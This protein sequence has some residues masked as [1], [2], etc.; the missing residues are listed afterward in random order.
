VFVCVAE[1][2]QAAGRER[3]RYAGAQDYFDRLDARTLPTHEGELNP[4]FT[5][6]YTSHILVK[7]RNRAAETALL[8][9]EK[10]CAAASALFAAAYPTCSLNSLWEC[11]SICQF[12]D[13]ICGCHVDEVTDDLNADYERIIRQS[14]RL[15][16]RALSVLAAEG[17][18]RA[19]AMLVFNPVAAP[20]RDM[21]RVAASPDW[22]PLDRD[23]QTLPAQRD[24]DATCVLV[25]SPGFGVSRL[26]G[27]AA[28]PPAAEVTSDP[29]ALDR[30]VLET[31]RCRVSIEHG[32]L[33]IV[34]KGV[35]DALLAPHG[36]GEI[37]FR[38]DRGDL[39]TEEL[40]GLRL[41]RD[42]CTERVVRVERGPVF[43]RVHLVGAALPLE[44]GVDRGMV[45]DGFDSLAWEKEYTF[46]EELDHFELRLSLVWHGSNTKVQI[47]FPLLLDPLTAAATYETPFG[48]AVR[49]PYYG[50]AVKNDERRRRVPANVFTRAKGDWPAL[51]WVDYSDERGGLTVANRGTPGHQ[52]QDGSVM[53]SLLRSPTRKA[54]AFVPGPSSWENGKRVYEFA[55][56]P[57]TG[58]ADMRS[59]DLGRRFNRPLTVQVPAVGSG[60]PPPSAESQ[61]TLLRID[62]PRVV[63]AAF[64]KAEHG[65]GHVARLYEP[66][67]QETTV[68][69]V[70]RFSFSACWT[71]D[72]NENLVEKTDG[73][74]LRFA[75]FEIKTLVFLPE[76]RSSAVPE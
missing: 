23:G 72:L 70:P 22:S 37:L 51:G 40:F 67:G 14:D 32:D 53:V 46:F 21:V 13:G 8:S 59:V 9:A 12:H 18:P 19:G 61:S 3:L 57:H 25:S 30:L 4:E 63:L 17:T 11:L 69:I 41:G 71:A 50:V 33:N 43:T 10:A 54:S 16:E 76:P 24:G 31:R 62:P 27:G 1:L 56:L 28:P 26:G 44:K 38:E 65:D 29:A 52:L 68:R 75:P 45:W 5:G 49:D 55:F 60:A 20:R 35:H 39:W 6:C 7:Q 64:K 36:F 42:A 48:C 73:A 47:A 74:A 15:R 34:S 2:N 66:L 58:G